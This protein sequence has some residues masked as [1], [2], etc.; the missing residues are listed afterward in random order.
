MEERKVIPNMPGKS[1]PRLNCDILG[2]PPE[3]GDEEWNT[4]LKK[5]YI[6]AKG[7]WVRKIRA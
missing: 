2:Y 1:R 3:V 7:G 4:K 6:K 5:L